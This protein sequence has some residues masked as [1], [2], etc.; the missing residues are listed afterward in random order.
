MGLRTALAY[1]GGD[2]RALLL[3]SL[4]LLPVAAGSGLPSK[5]LAQSSGASPAPSGAAE[6]P[7]ADASGGDPAARPKPKLGIDSLLRPR[8]MT[9]GRPAE[10]P[11]TE[12]TYAGRNREAWARLFVDARTELRDAEQSYEKSRKKLAEVSQGGSYT[13]NPLGGTE[14]SPTDPEVQKAKAQKERDKK[15]IE[16]AQKRLRELKVEASLAGVPDAW[17]PPDPDASP[18]APR[19][20]PPP[21]DSSRLQ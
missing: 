15:A 6:Q 16:A 18:S 21:A 9:S 8:G 11:P 2:M 3:L 7:P 14:S 19:T 1:N 13:Y 10:A 12:E 4:A 5:A 20:E 17:I